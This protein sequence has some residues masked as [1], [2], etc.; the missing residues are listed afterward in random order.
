MSALCVRRNRNAC[1]EAELKACGFKATC[2]SLE[3]L[4][5]AGANGPR[6]VPH[7]LPRDYRRPWTCISQGLGVLK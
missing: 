6:P 4:E 2:K 3:A 5:E 1:K 7:Q